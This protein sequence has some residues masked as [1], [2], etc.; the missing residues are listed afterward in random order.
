MDGIFSYCLSL[1]SLTDISKWNT[2]NVT[3]MKDIFLNCF[4]LISLPDI[5]KKND[6]KFVEEEMHSE[7]FQVSILN[8]IESQNKSLNF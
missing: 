7:N 3:N 5:T 6:D 4:S 2:S 8:D 1:V